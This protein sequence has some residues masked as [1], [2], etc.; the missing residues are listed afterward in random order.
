MFPV[1]ASAPFASA[2]VCDTPVLDAPSENATSQR[3][4]ESVLNVAND[5]AIVALVAPTGASSTRTSVVG[6]MAQLSPAAALT[7]SVFPA[8][9]AVDNADAKASWLIPL[10]AFGPCAYGIVRS[11]PLMVSCA[12]LGMGARLKAADSTTIN[13]PFTVACAPAPVAKAAINDVVYSSAH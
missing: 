13:W 12:P 2:A 1:C 10:C 8:G 9:I 6:A 5:V 7:D 3:S 11:T 4:A